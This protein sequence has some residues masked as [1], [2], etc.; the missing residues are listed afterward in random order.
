MFAQTASMRFVCT[1]LVLVSL[2][3]LAGCG[4]GAPARPAGV[5]V[6]GTVTLGGTP[7]AK[8]EIEINPDIEMDNSGPSTVVKI[9]DGKYETAPGIGVSPGYVV[10]NITVYGAPPAADGAE[11]S[12]EEQAGLLEILGVVMRKTEIPAEG[13]TALNFDLT[14]ADLKGRGEL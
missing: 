8:G 4:G 7:V 6:A 3:T 9:V 11:V 5:P 1:L 13:N 12:P 14:D 2:L 10:V